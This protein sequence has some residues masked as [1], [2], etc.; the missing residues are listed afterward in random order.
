MAASLFSEA[1]IE[2]YSR[3]I[4]LP[5]VGGAGQRKLLAS[6]AFVVGAGGLGSPALLYL[7]AA[8]VGTLG[9]ADGDAVELSNLHRQIIHTTSAIG[10]NKALSAEA[11]IRALN[12]DCEVRP[13]ATRLTAQNVR[14]ALRGYDV[15]LDGSDNFPTRFVVADACWLEGIPLVSAAVIAFEGQLMTVLPGEASPCYR[16]FLPEP[17]PPGL[18]PTCQEAGVLGTVAGVMGTLQATEAVKLLLGVGDL[19]SHHVLV[20][21]A[22]EGSFRVADRVADPGCPLCGEEPSIT[23]PADDPQASCSTGS[24]GS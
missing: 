12:P 11:A 19:L 7:A 2:R 23:E 4:L 3:Q 16:C 9:L 15:V 18:V 22:L 13:V 10:R 20:Y 5:E 1:E 17:P 6:R 14:A 24:C 8:G 21:D